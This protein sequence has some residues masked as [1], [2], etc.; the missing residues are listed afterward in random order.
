MALSTKNRTCR[1]HA[2]N[3]DDVFQLVS[4]S[5]TER[6]SGL[7]ELD[8]V[9]ASEDVD[10]KLD[11][12]VGQPLAVE[13]ALGTGERFFHGIVASFGLASAGG[14]RVEY[15]AKLVPWPWLLGR[16][17]D[18][19]IFQQ[20]SV[21]DIAKEVFDALDLTDYRIDAD[22]G[23][24]PALEYTVQYRETDLDFVS[25]LLEEHGIGFYFEHEK[26]KHTLV[27]FD[28]SD[29]NPDCP[30]HAK[31]SYVGEEAEQTPGIVT[32]WNA[33]LDLRSGACALQDYNFEDPSVDLMATQPTTKPVGGNDRLEVYEYPGSHQST[34][35]GSARARRRIEAEE[36]AAQVVDG[37]STCHDFSPGYRFELRGHDRKDFAG[38]Y[39]L[40]E[41]RHALEPDA[42]GS[43][44][45]NEFVC[46]P[47]SVRYRPLATTPRPRIHGAQTAVVV[48]EAGREIDV[49]DYGSVYLRFHW[50]RR[51][52]DLP[53]PTCRVRVAQHWAGKEWGAYFAP[54]IGQEVIVEF[55]DGDP[56]R[57]LVTGR[58]YNGQ[59]KPPY[60]NPE[61]GGIKSR[62]TKEGGADEF[63]EIRLVDSKGSELFFVQAQRDWQANVK[64]DAL[65]EVGRDRT[66]KVVND[67]KVE[68]GNDRTVDVKNDHTEKVGRNEKLEV[69][70]DR[71]RSVTGN[72]DVA[73]RKAQRIS[74]DE[75]RTLTVGKAHE[76]TIRDD[77]GEV[78]EGKYDLDV[79]KAWSGRAKT[80]SFEAADEVRI[81][82]GSAEIVMKK[83]GD[84]TISGKK[85]NVKGT[86]DVI[87]EGKSIKQ[88]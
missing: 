50:D 78:V 88:N 53:S 61:E 8:L 11:A 1:V 57:P 83:N 75:K 10:V 48:G 9:L 44:Y 6:I 28:A 2:P 52:E 21:L 24:Y 51:K 34:S 20:K 32:R 73:V 15:R 85:I 13:V 29:Q 62:S 35:E 68:I 31:A 81:R 27:L 30:V 77:Q 36:A 76:I 74:V 55:L 37:A 54:R 33:R 45:R 41:V 67:E 18:C 66:R 38:R 4:L 17:A 47:A 72:E 87:L 82:T 40:R 86:G 22:A 16:S 19:R 84:I 56:A 63:N 26:S 64:N 14:D 60:A 65:E 39:L 3:G 43:A 49:D 70:E 5:G 71:S 79:R 69:G 23:S 46:M 59:N 80:I 42:G 25:R 58:V 7:Y 12:L